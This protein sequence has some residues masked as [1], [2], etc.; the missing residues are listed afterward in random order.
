[1]RKR[2]AKKRE[3][4]PDPRFNDQ[5]VT[6][7]VNNLMWDGKKS[8]AFKVF[9]DAMDIVEEKKTDE[10]KSA[11]EI[12]KDGLSNV[13]PHVE[14][15]SRRVGG[16]TFQIPMQIRPDRKVSMAIKWLI[17]YT[18]KRNEKTMAQRLAAEILAAAKEEGA[19]VKKRVDTHKMAEAN[20]A[21]SHF[22]F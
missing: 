19:A 14:V 10:E 3:L 7:F 20:K 8:V 11:L 5:L 16:A 1:M 13:M 17:T 4:L 22:R 18:R 6:R 15:R 21:F 9:Y 12:W 2:K